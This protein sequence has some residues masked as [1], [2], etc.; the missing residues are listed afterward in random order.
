MALARVIDY[1]KAETPS[2]ECC[3][4]TYL[5]FLT[6][7]HKN[8]GGNKHRKQEGL[9]KGSATY[10]WIIHNDFPEGFRVL[11][12]NCNFSIGMYGYCPHNKS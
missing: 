2:C 10:W 4:E 8:G 5:E 7:D 12:M 9:E 1:S 11:C 6:L 3:G